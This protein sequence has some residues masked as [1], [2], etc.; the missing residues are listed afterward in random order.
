MG[1]VVQPQLQQGVIHPLRRMWIH[2]N[3][4]FQERFQLP[5]VVGKYW[6]EFLRVGL[7]PKEIQQNRLYFIK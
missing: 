6:D 7:D 3:H 1:P 2:L 5:R 4:V